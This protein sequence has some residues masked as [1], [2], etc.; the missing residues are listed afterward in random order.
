MG[1]SR[2]LVMKII[3][4]LRDERFLRFIG[5]VVFLIFLF[6]ILAYLRNTL[7]LNLRRLGLGL[8]FGFLNLTSGFDIG[9]HLIPFDRSQTFLRALLV[10]LLNTALVSGL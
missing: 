7:L 5:Q 3:S 8:G 1:P 10:G 4:L 9:E 6:A 2:S